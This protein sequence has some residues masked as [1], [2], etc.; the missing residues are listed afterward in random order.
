M[1]CVVSHREIVVVPHDP[2]VEVLVMEKGFQVVADSPPIVEG[3]VVSS[4]GT[5]KFS[6]QLNPVMRSNCFA[7]CLSC[8]FTL[9]SYLT[10][11]LF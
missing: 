5:F 9:L 11:R 1:A 4:K 3:E 6:V 8:G 10:F 7:L 2:L